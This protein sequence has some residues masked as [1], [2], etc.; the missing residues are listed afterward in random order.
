MGDESNN[1]T[2]LPSPDI[3]EIKS[4]LVKS[5]SGVQEE[6]SKFEFGLFFKKIKDKILPSALTHE[7]SNLRIY[8]DKNLTNQEPYIIFPSNNSTLIVSIIVSTFFRI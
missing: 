6:E 7:K 8:M 3:D 4:E 1:T 5:K 2:V